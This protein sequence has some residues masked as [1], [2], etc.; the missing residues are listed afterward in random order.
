MV[1]KSNENLKILKN[2]KKSLNMPDSKFILFGSRAKG[3]FHE[4]SDYD[5]LV[6]SD[7]FKNI[8]LHKRTINLQ[9]KWAEDKSL[10][11]LCFTNEEIK[12]LL[13]NTWGIVNEAIN[14]GIEID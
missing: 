4:D 5:V 14:T 1:Q 9:L 3:N 8:P 7:S 6:V 2:F 13:K 10:E 11:L 12:K